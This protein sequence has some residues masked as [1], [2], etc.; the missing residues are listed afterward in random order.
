[1]LG[2]AELQSRRSADLAGAITERAILSLAE[3]GKRKSA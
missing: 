3:R 2:E 1:L